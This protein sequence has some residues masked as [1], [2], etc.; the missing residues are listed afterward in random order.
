MARK[1]TFSQESSFPMLHS[2]AK[3]QI[4]KSWTQLISAQALASSNTKWLLFSPTV[5]AAPTE[6]GIVNA[7]FIYKRHLN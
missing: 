1:G 5:A 2:N 7:N 3:V 4:K 6:T